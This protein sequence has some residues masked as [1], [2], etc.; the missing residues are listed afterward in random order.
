M[1]KQYEKPMLAVERYELTQA[2][3]GCSGIKI[4]SSGIPGR[5]DVLKD[6]DST[7]AM[8]NWARING[9]LEGGANCVIILNGRTDV[10]GVCYHTNANAAFVS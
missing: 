4:T 5:E 7:N 10:D 9:F 3:A 6:P 1:K 8:K 2:I